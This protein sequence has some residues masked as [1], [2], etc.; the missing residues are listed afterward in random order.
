MLLLGWCL[1]GRLYCLSQRLP[2]NKL[3]ALRE[4]AKLVGTW[5]KPYVFR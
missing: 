2:E 3:L 4:R 1:A 5:L